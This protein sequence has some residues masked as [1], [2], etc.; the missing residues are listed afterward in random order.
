MNA[1]GF[2]F[3][4]TGDIEDARGVGLEKFLQLGRVGGL[5]RKMS[6][7]DERFTLTLA[8]ADGEGGTAAALDASQR[9]QGPRRENHRRIA[10]LHIFAGALGIVG[11]FCFGQ[12]I[13]GGNRAVFGAAAGR[14]VAGVQEVLCDREIQGRAVRAGLATADQAGREKNLFGHNGSEEGGGGT[15]FCRR[16]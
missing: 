4:V 12:I 13:A 10:Q 5:V 1:G 7:N 3:G 11:R 8:F 15:Y 9:G 2:G 6:E 16:S 14:A